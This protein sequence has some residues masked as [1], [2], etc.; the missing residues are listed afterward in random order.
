MKGRL[1][2]GLIFLFL[3][4]MSYSQSKERNLNK[5][6]SKDNRG[7]DNRLE[8]DNDANTCSS[9]GAGSACVG[10]CIEGLKKMKETGALW[11]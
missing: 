9:A 4:G 7:Q 8:S 6:Q 5:E 2:L 11:S 3:V 10:T 1:I